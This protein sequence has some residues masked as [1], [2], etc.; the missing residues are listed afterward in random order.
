MKCDVY[1]R[2]SQNSNIKTYF[3]DKT[4]NSNQ[5][6]TTF[7]PIDLNCQLHVF[8]VVFLTPEHGKKR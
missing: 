1:V 6:W 7:R 5:N 3:F 8:A 4:F 2:P